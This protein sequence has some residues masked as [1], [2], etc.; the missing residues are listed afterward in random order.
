MGDRLILGVWLWHASDPPLFTVDDVMLLK[1]MVERNLTLPHEWVCFTDRPEVFEGTGVRPIPLDPVAHI[2]GR[3]FDKVG[4]FRP[5]IGEMMGGNR[6]V[7][8]D[9]DVIPV[10]NMDH[11]FTRSEDLVL[12]RNPTRVPWKEPP[13]RWSVRDLY[14]ISLMMLTAGTRS[15]IW[16]DFAPHRV[17]PFY[18]AD[19]GY[20]S[21]KVGFDVPYWDDQH[22]V[23]RIARPNEPETGVNGELPLNAC[24]I[25]CPGS[26]GKATLPE[27]LERCPWIPEHRK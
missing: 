25:A 18:R 27:V 3:M 5:E 16:H 23:Y 22:G 6:I 2:K 26:H 7:V 24:F 9:L 1:R 20:I 17:T 11:L 14:N 10:G 4:L 8:M 15:D 19:Q 13:L 12:W 21:A